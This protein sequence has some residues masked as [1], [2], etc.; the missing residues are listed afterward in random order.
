MPGGVGAQPQPAGCSVAG[1]NTDS[2]LLKRECNFDIFKENKH[3]VVLQPTDMLAV[4]VLCWIDKMIQF[5][6]FEQGM[7]YGVKLADL[8]I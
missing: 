6:L 4:G 8:Q 5:M 7:V 2:L 3:F 1:K